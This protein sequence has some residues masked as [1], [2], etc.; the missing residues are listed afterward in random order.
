M[1]LEALKIEK[2]DYYHLYHLLKN[3]DKQVFI[4]TVIDYVYNDFCSKIEDLAYEER[5]KYLIPHFGWF[6]RSIPF[7]NPVK[8]KVAK[9][10]ERVGFCAK[11]KWDYP[12]RYLT[13][14]EAMNIIGHIDSMRSL[15][16]HRSLK[17]SILDDDFLLASDNLK[18]YMNSLEI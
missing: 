5:Y 1:D 11:N 12:E 4:N 16:N 7:S 8:I 18:H 9:D 2:H 13:Y 10:S 3:T 15:T 17:E 6:W 14:D